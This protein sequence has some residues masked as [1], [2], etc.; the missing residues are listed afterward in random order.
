MQTANKAAGKAQD[1]AAAGSKAAHGQAKKAYDA[2]AQAGSDAYDS[3]SD[4][5]SDAYDAAAS[6]AGS[7]QKGAK[8]VQLLSHLP[9]LP[10]KQ[11]VSCDKGQKGAE[12]S[13]ACHI[14]SVLA[15]R[16][17]QT[18]T[19]WQA[20]LPLTPMM[21]LPALWAAAR[22]APSR[23]GTPLAARQDKRLS[24]QAASPLFV[25][26]LVCI[27]QWSIIAGS[28]CAL[29]SCHQPQS[30]AVLHQVS[31]FAHADTVRRQLTGLVTADLRQG[32]QERQGSTGSG[33]AH[34]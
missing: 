14:C 23:S 10:A 8:Q 3:A 24:L 6:A 30:R 15:A 17:D 9:V 32:C 21:Q 26:R 29:C 19:T 11:K 31:T 2:T 16:L 34:L 4:T 20:I 7:G 28:L 33:R 22:R 27:R 25:D 5:A 13:G 12:R 18:R 1:S